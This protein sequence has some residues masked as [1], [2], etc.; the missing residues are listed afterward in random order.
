MKVFLM[1]LLLFIVT[2]NEGAM[3]IKDFKSEI[4]EPIKKLKVNIPTVI[5]F[6]VDQKNRALIE[7]IYAELIRKESNGNPNARGDLNLKDWAAG[8]LQI[9]MCCLKDVNKS[10]KTKYTSDDRFNVQASTEMFYLYLNKG[11]KRYAKKF[12]KPPTTRQIKAMWNGGIYGGYKNK[13]ALRYA[14]KA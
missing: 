3:D 12:G 14:D 4:L 8:I 5:D 6:E 9:R 2:P 1:F 7:G 10:Y 11:I 13:Q